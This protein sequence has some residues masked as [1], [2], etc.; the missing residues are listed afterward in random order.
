[1]G[2]ANEGVDRDKLRVV[3]SSEGRFRCSRSSTGRS[4]RAVSRAWRVTATDDGYLA[5][6]YSS[7]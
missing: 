5:V 7:P 4:L 6:V 2:S 1:L 3:A